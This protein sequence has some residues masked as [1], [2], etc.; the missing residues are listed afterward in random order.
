VVVALEGGYNLLN[1]GSGSAAI[2]RV[3]LEPALVPSD[4]FCEHS[5][6]E[7]DAVVHAG[8]MSA[9]NDTC[10]L[11]APWWPVLREASADT[12]QCDGCS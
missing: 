11:H 8:T 1:V 12:A 2:A 10:R 9:I 3:L 5:P 4:A 7:H 6:S